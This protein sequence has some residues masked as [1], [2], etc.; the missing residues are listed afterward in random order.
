MLEHMKAHQAAMADHIVVL[1]A[2]YGQLPEQQRSLTTLTGVAAG[3]CV[4]RAWV[5]GSPEHDG[6][7]V[8]PRRFPQPSRSSR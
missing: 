4:V 8:Q 3:E 1:K 5:R 2:F 7:V 6:R